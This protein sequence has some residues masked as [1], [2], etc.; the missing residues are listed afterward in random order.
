MAGIGSRIAFRKKVAKAPS[1]KRNFIANAAMTTLNFLVPLLTFPYV[2]RVLGPEGIGRVGFALS[3]V[4]NFS[5]FACL[6]GT[7]YGTRE[8]A[9]SRNDKKQLDIVFSELFILHSSANILAL[10]FFILTVLSVGQFRLELPIFLVASGYLLASALGIDWLY[11]GLESYGFIFF[12]NLAAKLISV[13]LLFLLVTGPKEVVSYT[14]VSISAL[15]VGNVWNLIGSIGRVRFTLHGIKPFRHLRGISTFYVISI[16]TVLSVNVDKT[17]IGLVAG[18]AALGLYSLADKVVFIG[19]SIT[20]SLSVVILPRV[21]YAFAN[22]DLD[23][24][25]RGL[26]LSWKFALFLALPLAIGTG[27][28]SPD[29]VELFGGPRFIAASIPLA[30]LSVNIFSITMAY[31]FGVQVLCARGKEAHYLM[32]LAM[33]VGTML[34]GMLILT[35]R[36]GIAGSALAMVLSYAVQAVSQF[37]LAREHLRGVMIFREDYRFLL[38]SL[39]MLGAVASI[40]LIPGFSLL[41]PVFRLAFGA[42]CGIGVYFIALLFFKEPLA[43]RAAEHARGMITRPFMGTPK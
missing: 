13:L 5:M 41:E 29:I 40:R 39:A 18:T 38:S 6:V 4:A 17:I 33:G 21:A 23:E 43:Q 10:L 36:F 37:V 31:I 28:M 30:L 9:R 7:I 19:V 42:S 24:L 27:L 20:S 3:V 35:P 11:Q 26:R 2:S 22:N 1:I 25:H 14:L 16:F 32:T 34:I 15:L 8:I 12:R